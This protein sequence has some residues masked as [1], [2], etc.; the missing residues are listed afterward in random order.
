[1]A[2]LYIIAGVI[3]LFLLVTAGI[4]FFAFSSPRPFR[5]KDTK[6]PSGVQY[7]YERERMLSMIA[8]LAAVPCEDVWIRSYDGLRLHGRYYHV[9]EGAPVQIQFHGYRGTA[10]RD[11]SGGCRLARSLGQNVLLVDQRAQGLSGGLTMPFGVRERRDCLSWVE[12]ALGRFGPD[13]DIFLAGVS[14]GAATVLMAAGLELPRNVRGIIADCP[15]D[16]PLNIIRKVCSEDMRLPAALLLPA[17]RAAA[18][19]FGRF[20]L[21]EASPLEAVRKTRIPILL[22]HGEADMFVPCGMSRRLFAECASPV[23]KLVTVPGAGHALS[24]IVDW[25]SYHD[26]MV[27]FFSLCESAAAV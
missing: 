3:A 9:R 14:M 18:R 6:L 26:A 24:F 10:I 25:Q 8:E 4:Y 17:V 23:K 13:T 11:F 12:Y 27:E 7:E 15:Y 20:S 1:M 21:A 19:I 22:I 16:T 2:V 5:T